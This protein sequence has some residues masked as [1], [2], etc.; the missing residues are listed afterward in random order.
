MKILPLAFV[1]G[2]T[3]L[4]LNTTASAFGPK[5]LLGGALGSDK[6]ETQA[7]TEGG[8]DTR[9][10]IVKRYI[11]ASSSLSKAQALLA[12]A[13]GLKTEAAKLRELTGV[14]TSGKVEQQKDQLK[15]HHTVS[16]SINEKIAAELGK[17]QQLSAE[18]KQQIALALLPYANGL[19][20]SRKVGQEAAPFLASVRPNNPLALANFNN[21]FGTLLFVS[22][23][24]PGFIKK[25][26]STFQQLLALAKK[27]GIEVPAKA[28]QQLKGLDI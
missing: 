26:Y 16:T 3:S 24:A 12:D 18:S 13:L 28:T 27:Q 20:Q 5:D 14:L 7:A 11:S 25:H 17:E 23:N 9:E 15:K 4:G 19:Y 8:A 22:K 6:Q 21:K 2:F 1:I 10:A